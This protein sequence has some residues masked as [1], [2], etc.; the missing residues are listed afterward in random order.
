M[1]LIMNTIAPNNNEPTEVESLFA[2]VASVEEA[3]NNPSHSDALGES[4]NL[5]G[6]CMGLAAESTVVTLTDAQRK[7]FSNRMKAIDE[8]L[9]EQAM[10]GFF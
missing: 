9:Q 2:K 1:A 8:Q 3:L 10:E 6:V 5:Y 4:L 7:E